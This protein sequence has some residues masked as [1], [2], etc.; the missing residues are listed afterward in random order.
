[1]NSHDTISSTH[2]AFAAAHGFKFLS[3]PGDHVEAG[4]GSA[5]EVVPAIR[6][7]V[8]NSDGS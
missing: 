2:K 1:M 6:S 3:T 5:A 4:E 7:F 8:A